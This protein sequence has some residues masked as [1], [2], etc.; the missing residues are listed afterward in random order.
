MSRRTYLSWLAVW[1]A[2]VVVYAVIQTAPNW[3]IPGWVNIPI[4][5]LGVVSLA[6]CCRWHWY[7][8]RCRVWSKLNARAA[9]DHARAHQR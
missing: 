4:I 6:Q 2:S 8:H 9:A 1:I 7:R 5:L 3:Q